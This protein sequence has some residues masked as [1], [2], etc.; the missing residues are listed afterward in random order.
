[1]NEP[2]RAVEP[3]PLPG[4]GYGWPADASSTPPSPH[5][6]RSIASAA[7]T[8]DVVGTRAVLADVALDGATPAALLRSRAGVRPLC[9]S[10]RAREALALAP[11]PRRHHF[12]PPDAAACP[13]RVAA[14]TVAMGPSAGSAAREHAGAPARGATG[15]PQTRPLVRAHRPGTGDAGS[16]SGSSAGGAGTHTLAPGRRRATAHSSRAFPLPRPVVD[17]SRRSARHGARSGSGRSRCRSVFRDAC[18]ALGHVLPCPGSTRR[19]RRRRNASRGV[20][21]SGPSLPLCVSPRWSR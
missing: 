18:G 4:G 3:K 16:F 8:R 9:G 11:L 1:M 19:L 5:S 7:V 2:E 20:W 21:W 14:A 10:S 15:A 12:A 13:N 17:R 6:R